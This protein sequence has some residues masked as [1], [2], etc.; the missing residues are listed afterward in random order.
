ME[1]TDW[2]DAE[3]A[4]LASRRY[5]AKFK[6]PC[7]VEPKILSMEVLYTTEHKH[8][9]VRDRRPTALQLEGYEVF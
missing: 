8:S 4:R 7:T 6:R 1:M 5:N 3:V 9:Q 2:V